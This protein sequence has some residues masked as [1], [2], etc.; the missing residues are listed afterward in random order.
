MSHAFDRVERFIGSDGLRRLAEAHVAVFG[1]GAVGSA[2]LEALAR[3][4]IGHLRLVDFDRIKA[5]NLNRQILALASTLGQ[6]KAVVARERV[7]LINPEAQVEAIEEFF[8]SACADRLLAPPLDFVIDAIDSLTPKANLIR[9]AVQRGIPIVSAMGAA[10]R[11]DATALHCSDLFESEGCTLARKVRK[12][13]R[14]MGVTGGVTAVWSS[15][16]PPVETRCASGPPDPDEADV[17]QRGRPR[18]PLP[19]L[20]PIPAMFGMMA[21]NHVIWALVRPCAVHRGR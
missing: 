11:V 16:I 9:E 21:A 4:G 18:P 17:P 14:R 12:R 19:S 3:S 10:N 1:L 8:C 6:P 20:M 15:E 5:S 13:L 2:A 7:A